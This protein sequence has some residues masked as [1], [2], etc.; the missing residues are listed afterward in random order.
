MKKEE[1]EKIIINLLDSSTT[2]TLGCALSDEPWVC[3]VFYARQGF[4]LVFFSSRNSRHSKVF[5][6]NRRA[7]ASIY[8]DCDSWR[9]IRGLQIEGRV[10]ILTKIPAVAKGTVTYFRKYP[11]AR[12]FFKAGSILSDGLAGKMS[13]VALYVFRPSS[14]WYLNNLD[15]LGVRWKLDIRNGLAVDP[16]VQA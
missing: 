14:I 1:L 7:A 9:D 13:A 12:E 4:D 2:M 16:P 15:G 8:K 10:N 11:F 3:S 6:E 5:K